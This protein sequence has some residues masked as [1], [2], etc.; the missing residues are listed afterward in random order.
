MFYQKIKNENYGLGTELYNSKYSSK[1]IFAEDKIKIDN[2]KD[3]ISFVKNVISKEVSVLFLYI[4]FSY[5]IRPSDSLRWR[6]VQRTEDMNFLMHRKTVSRLETLL[7][8]EGIPFVNPTSDLIEKDKK[9][10]CTI[11]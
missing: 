7:D 6:H 3:Y 2:Y 11:F 10:G 9:Q 4:P 5:D 8:Q 1:T